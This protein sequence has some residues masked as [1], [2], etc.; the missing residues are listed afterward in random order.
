M[1][2]IAP[3][4]SIALWLSGTPLLTLQSS[5]TAAFPN[6]A[7]I[8]TGYKI[9]W[10]LLAICVAAFLG[11]LTLVWPARVPPRLRS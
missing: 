7:F 11:L 5:H 2:I 6:G 8:A 9:H 1:L 3:L 4:A 10:T